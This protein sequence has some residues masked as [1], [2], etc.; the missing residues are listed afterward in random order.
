MAGLWV[1]FPSPPLLGDEA[2][3]ISHTYLQHVSCVSLLC[4]SA[5]RSIDRGRVP[6]LLGKPDF[7]PA[8]HA[9]ARIIR[10]YENTRQTILL[11]TFWREEAPAKKV[12]AKPDLSLDILQDLP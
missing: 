12:S 5:K 2:D 8:L 9:T 11:T 7:Q 6:S 4:D 1:F 10:P 3:R